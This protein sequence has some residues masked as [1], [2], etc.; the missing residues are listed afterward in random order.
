MPTLNERLKILGVRLLN[1]QLR[2]IRDNLNL[3]N[4]SMSKEVVAYLSSR[5]YVGNYRELET[6]LIGAII[7]A[8]SNGRNKI[9]SEDLREIDINKS[10]REKMANCY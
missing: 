8:Q 9:I 4:I 5:K 2:R 3:E 10:L 6:I 1:R 7:S